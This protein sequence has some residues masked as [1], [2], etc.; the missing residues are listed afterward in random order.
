M[1]NAI[2]VPKIGTTFKVQ[3]PYSWRQRNGV[4]ENVVIATGL[5]N[6][7][8]VV[9]QFNG[10]LY[11]SAEFLRPTPMS[12]LGIPGTATMSFSIPS[13]T[14]LIGLKLYQQVLAVSTNAP[15]VETA[16]TC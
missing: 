15:F 9:L 14:R 7:S 2:G 10:W 5:S 11:T 13:Q 3:V 16:N 1:L 12:P 6:P 4:G 8:V